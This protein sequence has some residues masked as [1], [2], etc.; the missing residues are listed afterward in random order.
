MKEGH[1]IE[2]YGGGFIVADYTGKRGKFGAAYAG[3]DGVWRDQPVG[4]P[5]FATR[6]DAEKWS[7]A[8]A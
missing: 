2:S 7:D 1:S 5:P 6:E 4:I 8:S 3:K